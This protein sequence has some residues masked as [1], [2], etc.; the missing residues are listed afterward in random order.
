MNKLLELAWRCDAATGADRELDRLIEYACASERI[1]KVELPMLEYTASLDAAMTLV[2]EGHKVASVGQNDSENTNRQWFAE[3]RRGHITSYSKAFPCWAATGPLALCAAALRARSEQETTWRRAMSKA[4][5]DI[6]IERQ[7]Q[8]EAEGWSPEHDDE[9]DGEQLVRAAACYALGT[10]KVSFKSGG[11]GFGVRGYE[12]WYYST[13]RAWPWA[14]EWWKPGPDRRRELVK[15]AALVVAEIE[16]IDRTT[17]DTTS[18][19]GGEK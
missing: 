14:D 17:L 9:H 4:I 18:G 3:I 10:R 6:A 8:V 12:E 2:L 13:H 1:G 15:A 19:E 7:R 5:E 16:R 11:S